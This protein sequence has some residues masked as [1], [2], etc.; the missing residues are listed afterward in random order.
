M[1]VNGDELRVL[2]HP[3]PPVGIVQ[4][5]YPLAET[6]R[7]LAGLD[8][9][10]LLLI[11]VALLGAGAGGALLTARVLRPVERMTRAAAAMGDAP[12]ARLPASGEDEFARL[13]GTFNRLLGRLEASFQHQARILEQQRRFTADASTS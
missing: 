3:A 10:L 2:T 11:P 8:R 4:A 13:A 9:A 1:A 7:A 5:A 6:N 12:S